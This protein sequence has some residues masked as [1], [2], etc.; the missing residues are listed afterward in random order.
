[1]SESKACTKCNI[2]KPS[3]A[4]DRH[5]HARDGLQSW[6]K[7]CTS[8]AVRAYTRSPR[9]KAV[10]RERGRRWRQDNPGYWR[11]RAYKMSTEQ[12]ENLLATQG[13]VCAICG[14]SE[15]GGTSWHLDH[16]HKCCPPRRSCGK[17][18]R[19]LLCLRCNTKAVPLVEDNPEL[20]GLARAYLDRW[21][22]AHAQA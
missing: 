15:H 5:K 11:F 8:E 7:S 17:C 4:F 14:T 20:I 21:G 19:G 13:G 1:M 12:Y 3:S 10:A 16:D 22:V 2:Q 9:G 18:W 6:C